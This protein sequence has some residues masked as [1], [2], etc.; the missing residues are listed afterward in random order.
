MQAT[1][2][3]ETKKGAGPSVRVMPPVVFYSCLI[4]GIA[5]EL[6]FPASIVLMTGWIRIA[7]GIGVAVAGFWFMM[8][9]H[10]KF[11][12]QGTPVPL[13]QETTTLVTSGAHG[14]SRNPMYVGGS[15]FY[16]GI[17]LAVGSVWMLASYAPLGLYLA[18]YVVPREEAYMERKFG[19][20]YLA[21]RA[22]VRRWL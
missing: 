6:V 3:N 7:V 19:R 2:M 15:L 22:A 21:Y 14:L 12:K 9:G 17:G 4:L 5:M 18:L 11:K 16:L 10:E 13:N 20:E 8:A 1:T